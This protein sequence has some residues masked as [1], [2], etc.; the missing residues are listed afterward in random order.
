MIPELGFLF[1]FRKIMLLSHSKQYTYESYYVKKHFKFK[2]KF[3]EGV[4]KNQPMHSN[5]SG[6]PSMCPILFGVI[7]VNEISS[8]PIKSQNFSPGS[9]TQGG[10]ELRK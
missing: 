9:W 1:H 8:L 4:H 3:K 10:G 7:K 5:H 6:A 2:P